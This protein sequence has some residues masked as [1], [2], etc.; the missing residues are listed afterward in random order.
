[1]IRRES[2]GKKCGQMIWRLAKWDAKP[3]LAFLTSSNIDLPSNEQTLLGISVPP[4][5]Q[6]CKEN[7]LWLILSTESSFFAFIDVFD[8]PLPLPL[9]VVAVF[10]LQPLDCQAK[11][12]PFL[13]YH[14]KTRYVFLGEVGYRFRT[15]YVPE[16]MMLLS[17]RQRSF[18]L[19]P[20]CQHSLF[21][22]P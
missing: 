4:P 1:M 11:V 3:H 15:R 8:P 5:E 16:G 12:A 2:T 10:V 14:H 7:G 22:S 9:P 21:M 20:H 13:T 17:G 18:L 19:C 6:C